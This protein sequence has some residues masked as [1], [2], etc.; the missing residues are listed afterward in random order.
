[1]L[2]WLKSFKSSPERYEQ[3]GTPQAEGEQPV[4]QVKPKVIVITGTSG[5]GRKEMAKQLSAKLGFPYLPSYTTR[6][7]RPH[8]K[9][10][11]NYHFITD[12]EFRAMAAKDNFFQTVRLERGKYGISKDELFLALETHQTVIVVANHEGAQAFQ[13]H[14]GNEVIRI[15]LYVTKDDIRLRLE[16]ESVPHEIVDEYLSNYTEQVAFKRESEYLLQNIDTAAT[17]EKIQHFLQ[18]KI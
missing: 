8:E 9:D 14:F 13:R 18:D 12:D 1:M 2:N 17:V 11:Q 16:R 6:S 5:S 7:A 15:F 10:G 3:E 4:Q